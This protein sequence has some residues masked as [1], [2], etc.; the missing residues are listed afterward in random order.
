MMA[1]VG[2]YIG[3]H[4]GHCWKDYGTL[5]LMK[6]EL[7]IRSMVDV[8]CGIGSQVRLAQ[9]MG[10]DA[11]GIDGDPDVR[12]DHVVDFTRGT[13]EPSRDF[14]LGWSVEFLEHVPERF[15]ENYMKVFERCSYVVCTASHMQSLYGWHYNIKPMDW[16]IGLFREWGFD[17]WPAMRA[18]CLGHSTMKPYAT[19]SP[20]GLTF[21]QDTGMVF[22]RHDAWNPYP[23]QVETEWTEV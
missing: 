4:G 1:D 6:E 19:N 17:Y 14:D 7:G 9:S 16:Y 18:L 20:N 10:M 21:L 15:S 8:G 3:G 22:R 23:V 11:V 12:P 13:L 5:R 2:A